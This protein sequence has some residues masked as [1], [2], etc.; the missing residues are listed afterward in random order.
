MPDRPTFDLEH[1]EQAKGFSLVAGVDEVGRGPLAGP[2]V[3]A[4][5][6]FTGPP[7]ASLGIRDSKKLNGRRRDALVLDIHLHAEAVSLG[8]V[9]PS[10]IDEMNIHRASLLAMSRAALSLSHRPDMLLVDGRFTPGTGIP[11]RAVVSGDSISLSI[12]AASI[13]AKTA[14]DRMMAS[15]DRIYPAYGFASNKGYP[16]EVHR[17]VLAEIG[18]C[19][20]HR[21]S[22]NGVVVDR[23]DAAPA[24]RRP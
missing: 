10:E 24:G 8:V 23:D 1:E 18:P 5:V 19:P 4:A 16:S 15:Y 21:R 17:R 9:W 22:F 13:I 6:V 20:I 12:A 11:E 2:V 7:P 14:R 3:A